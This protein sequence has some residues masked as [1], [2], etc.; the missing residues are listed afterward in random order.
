M[1]FSIVAAVV[2]AAAAL[3]SNFVTSFMKKE[4]SKEDPCIRA[5]AVL[6][7]VAAGWLCTGGQSPCDSKFH[8]QLRVL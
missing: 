6:R 3:L 7:L 8:S 4:V 2:L 5:K 1:Y